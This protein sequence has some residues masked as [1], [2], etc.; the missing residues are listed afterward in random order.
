MV[1]ISEIA[2]PKNDY[3]LN[4]PRYIDSAEPEDLQDIEGHLL[5]G[6]PERDIDDPVRLKAYW[7]VL[8]NVRTALFELNRPGYSQLRVSIADIKS[9]IFEHAE[10]NSFQKKTSRIFEKWKDGNTPPSQ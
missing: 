7:S 10:F 5:G 8:P 9:T 2:D 1:P 3:N 4:L 6:I